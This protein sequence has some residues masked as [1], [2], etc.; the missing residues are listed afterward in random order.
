MDDDFPRALCHQDDVDERI[1][2]W[3]MKH[4]TPINEEEIRDIMASVHVDF[5]DC[6]CSCCM[7]A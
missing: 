1:Q 2:A 6:D 4:S 3:E 5:E 7:A